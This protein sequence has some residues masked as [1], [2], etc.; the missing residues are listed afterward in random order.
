MTGTRLT[1]VVLG[2]IAGLIGLLLAAAGVALLVFDSSQQDAD[3]FFTSSPYEL[4]TDGY[5]ITAE[6]LDL[7]VEAEPAGWTPVVGDLRTRVT[8]EPSDAADEVFIG[9]AERA[10]V[11]RY[12]GGV[13]HDVITRLGTDPA[14]VAYGRI[15]G[16]RAPDRP[17]TQ[18]FWE[19][20]SAGAGEQTITW[21]VQSGQWAVV[22]M[23][24]DASAGLAVT[25]TAGVATSLLTPIAI[26]LVVFGLL[27]LGGAIALLIAATAGAADRAP[28]EPI[29]VGRGAP[30]TDRVYPVAVE[31]VLDDPGRGLW[32]IKWLL[33]IPHYIVLALLWI[34]FAL[35]TFVAGIVILF[36]GRY[37]RGIFVFTSGVLR[38][39]WRVAY[40]G[41]SALGT[42]RYPPF[43]L[44]DVA[45][46]PARLDVAEPGPL[47]RGLVLIKWWLLAIPHYIVLGI[48]V[49][50]GVTWT[51]ADGTAD[52]VQ[53]AGGGLIFLLTIIAGF[54]LL[55]TSR[56]PQGLFDFVMGLNRWVYRVIAYVALMTDEYP[57]FRLDGGADEPAPPSDIP[58]SDDA[59]VTAPRP[60]E[61]SAADV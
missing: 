43:T 17:D 48:L 50:N 53:V 18:T 13:R 34:A 35:L 47:S 40:Y 6:D 52:R 56:Y 2:A 41:Y 5:A 12:L 33:L 30:P 36:T 46:Y 22:V 38:W 42:D 57:P 20:S 44:A 58:P 25:A 59:T 10:D 26:G 29:A 60:P 19:A 21:D 45:D 23:P 28:G 4:A 55:F 7:R 37:P 14:D 16:D 31:A 15:A 39:T 61:R 49:G 51:F 32:L 8:V 1:L 9:I 24:A 54:A 3:G 11:D 27:A